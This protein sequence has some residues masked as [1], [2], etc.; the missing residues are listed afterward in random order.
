[1]AKLSHPA[2]MPVFDVGDV[3]NGVYIVMPLITGGTLHDWI[4]AAQRPWR[5]VLDRFVA[6]GR[7]LAAAHAGGLIHRDFKPRNVMLDGDS[8]L[9]ADFGI[10][11]QTEPS[12]AMGG[13]ASASQPST[14]SGTPAYM[15]PEQARGDDLDARA[16]Q[17]SFCVS[18]WEGLHG[19]R[20]QQAETRTSGVL[21]SGG[22]PDVPSDRRGTPAWLLAAVARG[23]AVKPETRWPSLTSLLTHIERRRGRRRRIALVVAALTVA[24]AASAAVFYAP[25]ARVGACP[26]PATRLEAVWNP[27]VKARLEAAAA[28]T[29]LPYTTTVL[30]RVVPSLDRHAASWRSSHIETCQVHRGKRDSGTALDLQMRCLDRALVEFGGTAELLASI[31]NGKEFD[32]AVDAARAIAPL[33]ACADV[34]TLG[35]VSPPPAKRI[36]ADGIAADVQT[37]AF[38]RLGGKFQGLTNRAAEVVGRARALDHAP[39][40][41][42]ALKEQAAIAT[43]ESDGPK[44]RAA[45]EELA[46]VAARAGNDRTSASAWTSLVRVLGNSLQLPDEAR[47]LV[48]VARAAVARAGDPVDL[49]VQLLQTEA[50]M[51]GGYGE[52][53][54]ALELLEDARK[55]L[56]GAGQGGR[57]DTDLLLSVLSAT[58]AAQGHAG[59]FDDSIATFR[60]ALAVAEGHVGSDHP[61]VASL[62]ANIG[63]TLRRARRFEE[64]LVAYQDAARVT[65]LGNGE[66]LALAKA[67]ADVAASLIKVER[68]EESKRWFDRAISLTDRVSAPQDPGRITILMNFALLLR[69]MGRLEDSLAQSDRVIALYDASK[70]QSINVAIGI[71]NRAGTL[72]ELGR[73]QAAI[74]DYER[75]V[76]MIDAAPGNDRHLVSSLVGLG[77]AHLDARHPALAIPVLERAGGITAP[78]RDEHLQRIGRW[79][80][81]RAYVEARRDVRKGLAEVRA[82]RAQ[83]VAAGIP[84]DE[85]AELDT[86]LAK[87]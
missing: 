16:D 38:A 59:K 6:A 23:F 35:K 15:A 71:H 26:D 29:K 69:T 62:H 25:A 73:T 1:M 50:M 77:L 63:S 67:W 47:R 72:R 55:I 20:P 21:A 56:A 24:A 11:A 61:R 68:L 75:A 30:A 33:S 13:T 9:V 54:R 57:D 60:T 45:L 31:T 18:L 19:E 14:I 17:Y 66:S 12:M 65:E 41:A 79:L 10:A 37:I 4:H 84:A 8:L 3:A 51:I 43:A 83:L 27:A 81:G 58:G 70:S 85:L 22:V 7:G 80:L 53:D 87:H 2:V 28:A 78:G 44:A 46:Q 82:A 48:P 32:R 42:L 34:K 49:Q 86:W 5:Q 39:T 52:A 74:T 64:A 36:V 40:L 76:A